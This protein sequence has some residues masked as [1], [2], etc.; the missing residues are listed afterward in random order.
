MYNDIGTQYKFIRKGYTMPDYK[1]MY[2]RLFRAM[3]EATEIL[4]NRA[5]TEAIAIIKKAQQD[6]E[7][8]YIS[9]PGADT[10]DGE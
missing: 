5:M 6:T 4:Q 3:T 2:E 8:M 10:N 7:E 9:A 1:A